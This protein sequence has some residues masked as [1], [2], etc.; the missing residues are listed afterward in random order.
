[1][2]ED[3]RHRRWNAISW[4]AAFCE[5]SEQTFQ[6]YV[7][8][9]PICA[10]CTDGTRLGVYRKTTDTTTSHFCDSY[11]ISTHPFLYRKYKYVF[12]LFWIVEQN[13]LQTSKNIYKEHYLILTR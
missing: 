4:W 8:I 12:E 2:E 10:I 11:S 13:V 5:K 3:H 7:P 9:T 1:M 6:N